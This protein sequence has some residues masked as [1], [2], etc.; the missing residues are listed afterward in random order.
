MAGYLRQQAGPDVLLSQVA[1]F[2]MKRW[3]KEDL[4][5]PLDNL[6]EEAGFIGGEGASAMYPQYFNKLLTHAGGKRAIYFV[7]EKNLV[8]ALLVNPSLLR[9]VGYNA[10]PTDWAGF[11]EM[12]AVLGNT[13]GVP[14]ISGLGEVTT[15]GDPFPEGTASVWT[16]LSCMENGAD[17]HAQVVAGEVEFTS[18]AIRRPLERLRELWRVGMDAQENNMRSIV[19]LFRNQQ[20]MPVAPDTLSGNRAR[21]RRGALMPSHWP[22]L[23][24]QN[25]KPRCIPVSTHAIFLPKK[26]LGDNGHAQRNLNGARDAAR[27]FLERDIIKNRV[28]IHGDL[29]INSSYVDAEDWFPAELMS[30]EYNYTFVEPIQDAFPREMTMQFMKLLAYLR[31]M[32]GE[33]VE[34]A[35]LGLEALRRAQYYRQALEPHVSPAPDVYTDVQI[36][37]T[38]ST[39]NAVAHYTLDGVYPTM[40]SPQY[41][42]PITL[43]PGS[44]MVRVV[45]ICEGLADSAPVEGTYTVAEP[46]DFRILLGLTIV[47][48][49]ALVVA[50]VVLF[51]FSGE[52]AKKRALYNNN[53]VAEATACAIAAM[54]FHSVAYLNEIPNPNRIQQSF[55]SIVDILKELRPYLPNAVLLHLQEGGGE[56]SDGDGSNDESVLKVFDVEDAGSD[57]N[58]SPARDPNRWPARGSPQRRRVG[59]GLTGGGMQMQ[60]RTAGI[61]RVAVPSVHSPQFLADE[62]NL[63]STILRFIT[64]TAMSCC[65]SS[66]GVAEFFGDGD[67]LLTF[68]TSRPVPSRLIYERALSAANTI[69]RVVQCSPIV[70]PTFHWRVVCTSGSVSTGTAG[71]GDMKKYHT[72][73]RALMMT[74]VLK[75]LDLKGQPRRV[76]CDEGMLEHG[77]LQYL[78]FY[79]D[80][81]EIEGQMALVGEIIDEHVVKRGE[82]MYELDAI[83]Q[84]N[85]GAALNR[86]AYRAYAYCDIDA[87]LGALTKYSALVQPVRGDVHW[88]A[89]CLRAK[90][91]GH[92]LQPTFC[93]G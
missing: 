80:A 33:A 4:L 76:L 49:L 90:L 12:L 15:A 38:C 36:S 25:P 59:F 30:A 74:S 78:G 17:L 37:M 62:G 45:C 35:L 11:L 40:H 70:P 52:R 57:P 68:N 77:R 67:L 21:I 91:N 2:S 26:L 39:A 5:M 65:E 69:R 1:G 8:D 41:H 83:E 22:Q 73:G 66:R 88:A 50:G 44:L 55:I 7:P 10:V 54:D 85:P 16:H 19:K 34:S 53:A 72:F 18:D 32:S 92:R 56:G 9:E 6:Y 82:W 46:S 81:F 89:D 51:M 63:I 93:W 24:P 14:M 86:D 28:S 23:D 58:Q 42:G 79:F 84:A 87:A 75:R 43:P 3:V 60:T 48:V 27:F 20:V 47:A 71:G 31:T 13:T 64:E 61:V 29:P